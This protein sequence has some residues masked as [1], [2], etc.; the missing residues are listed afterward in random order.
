MAAHK[1]ISEDYAENR[2]DE[3]LELVDL[4]ADEQ[5]KDGTD[6]NGSSDDR[7]SKELHMEMPCYGRRSK[8][9]E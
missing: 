7:R 3:L 9:I 4:A 2:I 6:G 8:G 1:A 5:R